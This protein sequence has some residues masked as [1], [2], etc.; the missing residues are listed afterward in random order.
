MKK[1]LTLTLLFVFALSTT[2][3][4]DIAK[5]AKTAK[6]LV[7]AAAVSGDDAKIEKAKTAVMSLFENDA[8]NKDYT[9]L[10]AKA[11]YYSVLAGKDEAARATAQITGDAFKTMHPGVSY[12][13][14]QAFKM[15]LPLAEK[16]AQKTAVM[17][18]ISE[19]DNG[20]ANDLS[21]AFDNQNF[22]AAYEAGQGVL[23]SYELIGNKSFITDEAG[24]NQWKYYT[25]LAAKSS[26]KMDAAKSIMNSLA[27]AGYEEV[28]VYE[29]LFD[30]LIAEGNTD[31]AFVALGKGRK[32]D[33]TNSNLL[34]AEI[35]YLIKEK[36]YDKL[37]TLLK[38]AI[39]A[40][41]DNPSV[42]ATLGTVYNNLHKSSNES[43]DAAAADKYFTES[44]T[45]YE[46]ASE[47]DPTYFGSQYSLGELYYNKAAGTITELQ[48]LESDFSKAALAKYDAKKA[49]MLGFF[50]QALP[51]FKKAEQLNPNDK[52]TMIAMKEIFA[53][54]D[55]LATSNQL[56][57]RIQE[58]EG[59]KTFDKPFFN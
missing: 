19:I 40:E 57:E 25:G 12:K 44:K 7:A 56:K 46:K 2:Y 1:L 51:Y 27:D 52:N 17:N 37:E 29:T 20:M 45:Y 36:S 9:A 50:E 6:K 30:V 55:D 32:L 14:L 47:V 54:K 18:G 28:G 21:E 35:N 8:A 5:A 58:L 43:G 33:P 3:A 39:D 23:E 42:Y 59:G 38:Q 41:P 16:S 10:M 24:L 22:E 11:G 13:A 26:G 4:Q 31:A 48:A 49:E 53:R 15:A 34:F